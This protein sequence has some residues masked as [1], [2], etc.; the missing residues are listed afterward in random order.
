MLDSQII[1]FSSQSSFFRRVPCMSKSAAPAETSCRDKQS[2][3]HICKSLFLETPLLHGSVET[4]TD[5]TNARD[6]LWYGFRCIQTGSCRSHS[7]IPR[8][9]KKPK[10]KKQ[11]QTKT[12]KK[13]NMTSCIL[14]LFQLTSTSLISLRQS[15]NTLTV[16]LSIMS[17]GGRH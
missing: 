11:T 14:L 7:T 16:T 6:C 9:T 4:A 1:C 13:G 12:K 5:K 8:L 17:M 10:P 2:L 3:G 15:K